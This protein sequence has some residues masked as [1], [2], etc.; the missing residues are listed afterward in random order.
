[1]FVITSFSN[2]ILNS[3]INNNKDDDNNNNNTTIMEHHHNHVE[4]MMHDHHQMMMMGMGSMN[5]DDASSSGD[6][7]FCQGMGMVMYMEGFQWSL[8]RK[9]TQPHSCLNFYFP[10]WTLDTRTKFIGAMICIVVMG[11][12]TEGIGR[13]KHDVNKEARKVSATSTRSANTATAI[14]D[15][16]WYV[17]TLLQGCSVFMAYVLMLIVMTYSLEMLCSVIVG[18]VLGYFIFGG[19]L[20]NHASSPCCQFLEDE[21]EDDN[22]E[23]TV[24]ATLMRALLSTTTRN[25]EDDDNNNDVDGN[26]HGDDDDE[27]ENHNHNRHNNSNNINNNGYTSPNLT[28]RTG[29]VEPS[30]CSGNNSNSHSAPSV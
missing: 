28:S 10:S 18:L 26:N 6:N 8:W 13:L 1:L 27:E 14:Q 22:G 3:I 21:D 5:D 30:C 7:V 12:A 11:I 19:D 9:E 23:G 4:M 24:T 16:L 29:G 15:R 25:S 2:S 20:Y 17:Q